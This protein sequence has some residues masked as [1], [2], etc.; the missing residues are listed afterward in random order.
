M[1]ERTYDINKSITAQERYGIDNNLPQFAPGDGNCFSCKRNIYTK[2][3]R[4]ERNR[5]SKEVTGIRITGITLERASNELI[6]GC[7]HCCRTYC[8]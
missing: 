3:E 4:E 8:D 7:P 2:F 6:T 1:E 5:L